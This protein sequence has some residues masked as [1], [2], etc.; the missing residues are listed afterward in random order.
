MDPRSVRGDV[1]V[2]VYGKADFEDIPTYVRDDGRKSQLTNLIMRESIRE[3]IVRRADPY[4]FVDPGEDSEGEL[5][6]ASAV[7][8]RVTRRR[9]PSDALD[10]TVGQRLLDL[11]HMA[12]EEEQKEDNNRELAGLAG[13]MSMEDLQDKMY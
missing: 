8:P 1:T 9:F 11:S 13:G 5:I 3:H 10:N 7:R 6:V 2:F 4:T 12:Y